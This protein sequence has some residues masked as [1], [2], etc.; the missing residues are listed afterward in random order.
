MRV[1]VS[2]PFHGESWSKWQVNRSISCAHVSSFSYFHL[3]FQA[4][5][6]SLF[7]LSLSRKLQA[8]ITKAARMSARRGLRTRV[9]DANMSMVENNYKAALERLERSRRAT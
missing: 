9:Y 4:N 7:S 1:Y 3:S 6:R 8:T 5:L 2:G